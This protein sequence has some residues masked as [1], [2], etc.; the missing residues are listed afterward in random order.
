M[1]RR[2]NY[3]SCPHVCGIGVVF[4]GSSDVCWIGTYRWVGVEHE[5]AHRW[6]IHLC[7]SV[8]YRWVGVKR[9]DSAHRWVRHS[10]EAVSFRLLLLNDGKT[11]NRWVQSLSSVHLLLLNVPNRWVQNLAQDDAE[12]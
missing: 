7:V 12:E 5:G 3:L 11:P 10:C 1:M 2:M 6:V 8:A 4:E 9:C